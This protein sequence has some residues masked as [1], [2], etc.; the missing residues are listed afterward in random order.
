MGKSLNKVYL[1]GHVGFKPELKISKTGNNFCA[2]SLAT[3]EDVKDKATN[4]YKTTT[5][6]HNILSFGKTA[7]LFSKYV[8]KG[9]KIHIEG[10]LSYSPVENSKAFQC[11]I[12]M[13][14]FIILEKKQNDTDGQNEK[15]DVNKFE[16]DDLPPF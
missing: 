13:K 6:W 1:I 15:G 9:S 11:K 16:D 10:S 8:D 2:F 7:E 12:I 5:Q 14:D 3:N 4:Q